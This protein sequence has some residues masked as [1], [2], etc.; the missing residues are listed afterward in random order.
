MARKKYSNADIAKLAKQDKASLTPYERRL[1]NAHVRGLTREQ[2]RG[3]AKEKGLTPIKELKVKGALPT[4]G[5]KVPKAKRKSYGRAVMKSGDGTGRRVNAASMQ[6]LQNHLAKAKGNTKLEVIYLANVKTGQEIRAVSKGG[7]VSDLQTL[8][9]E[10]TAQGMPYKEA[11]K[12]AVINN[13]SLYSGRSS[14]LQEDLP[15]ELTNVVMYL[16]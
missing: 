15:D 14:D 7:T 8:I 16:H 9:K 2:A 6:S 3:H 1:A 12:A 11:F 5:G 4:I 13:Y 10:Y